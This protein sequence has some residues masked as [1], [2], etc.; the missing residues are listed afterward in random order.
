MSILYMQQ[1]KELDQEHTDLVRADLRNHCNDFR[2]LKFVLF[3]IVSF[4]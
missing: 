3:V 1:K 4:P 2:K